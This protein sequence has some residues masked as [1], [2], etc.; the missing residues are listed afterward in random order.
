M[1]RAEYFCDEYKYPGYD[2]GYFLLLAV[3]F[4]LIDMGEKRKV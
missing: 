1:D 2:V 3:V 4:V